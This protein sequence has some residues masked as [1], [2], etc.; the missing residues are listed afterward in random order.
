MAF[1]ADFTADVQ[2]GSSPLV[3]QFTDTSTISLPEGTQVNRWEWNF[4]DGRT[5][6]Q[7]NPSNT[8]Y[9]TSGTQTFTITL[10]VHSSIDP[11]DPLNETR[12]ETKLLFISVDNVAIVK[13]D[14]QRL[15]NPFRFEEPKQI[16]LLDFLPSYLQGTETSDFLAVFEKFLNEMYLGTNRFFNPTDGTDIIPRYTIPIIW[17]EGTNVLTSPRGKFT[18]FFEVGDYIK[19]DK[20]TKYYLIK[21]VLSDEL[22]TLHED[23]TK[24]PGIIH[25]SSKVFYDNFTLDIPESVDEFAEL[26]EGGLRGFWIPRTELAP[27]GMDGEMEFTYK[28]EKSLN[29]MVCISADVTPENNFSTSK[30]ASQVKDN[31][32]FELDMALATTQ[33][34]PIDFGILI[35]NSDG[36][37]FD[38]GTK[39]NPYIKFVYQR[40]QVDINTN[41]PGR[42]IVFID[43]IEVAFIR[44][45]NLNRI[46]FF[47][48][49][50]KDISSGA[51]VF[52]INLVEPFIKDDLT[53]D[54]FG[55]ERVR[56]F[57]NKFRFTKLFTSLDDN[58]LNSLY[59]KNSLGQAWNRVFFKA[60][61]GFLGDFDPSDSTIF[62]LPANPRK[63]PFYGRDIILDGQCIYIP[64]LDDDK[65][66]RL[67]K[68]DLEESPSVSDRNFIEGKQKISILEKIKRVC[69]LHDPDL[70]D[71]EY[72]QFFANYLGYKVDVSVEDLNIV[73]ATNEGETTFENLTP[74]EQ[75]QLQEKYLRFVMRNLPHWYQIKTSRSALNILL[76]SFGLVA[77]IRNYFTDDYQ[78]RE[79][80]KLESDFA[81]DTVDASFFET[82]HFTVLINLDESFGGFSL[83]SAKIASIIKT[84]L[85]VK[86]VNTVLR[87]LNGF[88]RREIEILVGAYT[89]WSHHHVIPKD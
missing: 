88:V 22:M 43:G 70:I 47:I 7:Q 40:T 16:R 67:Q 55:F 62:T 11:D 83:E 74:L 15:D 75:S 57:F 44:L 8:F 24:Q 13:R 17:K 20:E 84:I 58:T 48:K 2:S 51:I 86:P 1:V 5:S 12:I 61:S 85:S 82:P 38:S 26:E 66:L 64:F 60:D 23:Y 36:T 78:D 37:D 9:S 56:G 68:I 31:Y 49:V 39:T 29:R 18:E 33:T 59:F 65:N 6:T 46:D 19:R 69:E 27:V 3:V 89:R 53:E 81:F 73:V 54:F 76:Y 35:D 71:L 4:G 10:T 14:F 30:L 50:E 77:D 63:M 34:S 42:V 80:F 25:F 87:S 21:Q 41:L 79:K 32:L 45:D 28:V 52:E 72:I